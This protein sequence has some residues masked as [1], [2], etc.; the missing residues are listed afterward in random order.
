[1]LLKTINKN[2]GNFLYTLKIKVIAYLKS[3][4]KKKTRR[5]ITYLR[6]LNQ[7]CKSYSSPKTKPDIRRI[8]TYLRFMINYSL[9]EYMQHI[10]NLGLVKKD[11]WYGSLQHYFYLL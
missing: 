2:I 8:N 4:K 5:G 9:T 6:H 1:M 7:F 11:V 3:K 10:F